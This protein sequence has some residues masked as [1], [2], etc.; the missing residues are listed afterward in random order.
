M[1]LHFNYILNK[2]Y[3][4]AVQ[5]TLPHQHRDN[6]SMETLFK[7]SIL[8]DVLHGIKTKFK[9]CYIVLIFIFPMH[10]ITRSF[11]TIPSMFTSTYNSDSITSYFTNPNY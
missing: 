7:N 4:R 3:V 8:P 11:K 10:S 5:I 1:T 6:D 2:I 9:P